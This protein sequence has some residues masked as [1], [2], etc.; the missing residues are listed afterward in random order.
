MQ[1]H[2]SREIRAGEDHQNQARTNAHIALSSTSQ[3]VT[4]AAKN[5]PEQ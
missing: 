4:Q 1:N 5:T 3:R 2:Q